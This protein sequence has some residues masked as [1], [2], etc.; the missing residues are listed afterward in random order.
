MENRDFEAEQTLLMI[1][2]NDYPFW[3]GFLLGGVIALM[4]A[5]VWM[6]PG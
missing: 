5:A 1:A 6:L 2:L 4:F 3:C